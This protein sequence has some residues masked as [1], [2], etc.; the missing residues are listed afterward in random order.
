MRASNRVY[1]SA[2]RVLILAVLVWLIALPL[3]QSRPAPT[4]AVI[5]ARVF[6]GV[7]A[8]PWAEA[9]AIRGE[10]IVAV[11]TSAA[12]RALTGT[13]TRIVDAG[14]QLVIPG[15]NDAHVHAG[16]GPVAVRL[17]GPPAVVHDPSLEEVLARLTAAVAKAPAGSWIEGE[18][19]STLV[20][21]PKAT[22]FALDTVAPDH[23][24]ALT[25]WTGHGTLF[26]SAALRHLG[27]KDDERDPPG[28]FYVRM[29]GSRTITGL[30]YEYADYLLR[31]RITAEPPAEAQAAAFRA[32]GREAASLGITSVQLMTTALA[33]PDAVRAIVAGDV[34]QRVRVID[35]PL[36]AM[37]AWREPASRTT[38]SVS[39]VTVSGTKWIL[40]GTPIERLMFLRSP[41]ADRPQTS[42]RLN[43]TAEE[44]DGFLRQALAAREQPLVHAVGDGAINVLLDALERTGGDRWRPLRPRLEH[45]DLLD[46]SQFERARRVGAVLV[47]NPSHLMLRETMEARIGP[48]RVGRAWLLKTALA[49]GIPVALGSDGPISPF[50]NI[51]FATIN[52]NNPPEALTREQALLAYTSGAAFAELKEKEK[53]TIAPGMLA[54]LSI[55]SQDVFRVPAEAL[56]ATTS[57]LTVVGGRVVHESR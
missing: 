6:T 36:T 5:N 38:R 49:Q 20:D 40:D 32:F 3:A 24:V 8:R 45:G 55:L 13:E 44:L 19:G 12:I 4:L 26:N 27:I 18:I 31:R 53:G 54:D 7:A 29:P 14:G 15:I 9:V 50:L 37:A 56:P 47:Q 35:F 21:D 42:G 25:A 43:F 30:A 52:A 39:R 34:P 46:P 28:G 51:M 57:V 41:F 1:N 16:A 11:D 17:E 23:L 2:M 10:R 48:S 33:T 22:R